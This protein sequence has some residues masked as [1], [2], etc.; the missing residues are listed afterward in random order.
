MDFL[1]EFIFEVVLEGIF[2]LTVKNPKVKLWVRTAVFLLIAELFPVV[3]G[4]A[5]VS[6]YR[7]GN[8]SGGIV[9]IIICTALAI[10]FLIGGIYGHKRNWK[11][12]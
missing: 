6:M 4:I 8:T 5:A 1:M 10:G 11:Q 2:E 3:I 7:N 9:G 12:D